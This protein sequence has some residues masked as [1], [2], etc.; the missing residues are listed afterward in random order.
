MQRAW[1]SV[2]GRRRG[3]LADGAVARGSAAAATGT[4][5][6]GAAAGKGEA[7]VPAEVCAEAIVDGV[8]V[9]GGPLRP[10]GIVDVGAVGA[11]RRRKGRRRV[12]WRRGGRRGRDGRRSRCLAGRTAS[13]ARRCRSAR[14]CRRRPR[15]APACRG[16]AHRPARI[17]AASALPV[18]VGVPSPAMRATARRQRVGAVASLAATAVATAALAAVADRRHRPVGDGD[19]ARAVAAAK[20]SCIRSRRGASSSGLRRFDVAHQGAELPVILR[21]ALG[22]DRHRSVDRGEE[23][24]AVQAGGDDRQRAARSGPWRADR[25]RRPARCR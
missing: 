9:A 12:Q 25:R 19:L 18:R 10:D 3:E 8:A 11:T 14:R 15:K 17:Q 21:P 13:P 7:A 20:G 24:R 23:A 2:G 5:G 1:R 16:A 22:L 4:V 6:G